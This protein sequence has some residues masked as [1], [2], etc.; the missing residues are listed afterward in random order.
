MRC[1]WCMWQISCLDEDHADDDYGFNDDEDD[2]DNEGY[3]D[4][5]NDHDHD[6]T[7]LLESLKRCKSVA[8]LVFPDACDNLVLPRLHWF[9]PNLYWYTF[10]LHRFTPNLIWFTFYL[11]WFTPHL[12]WFTF[13]LHQSST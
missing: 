2:G 6:S 5:R 4:N 8:M 13:H 9:P 10:H 11:H 12:Y 7:P 3:D 1:M